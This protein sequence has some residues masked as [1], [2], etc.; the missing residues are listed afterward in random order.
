VA[1]RVNVSVMI[2]PN[3]ISASDVDGSRYR[4]RIS[5]RSDAVAKGTFCEKE[6]DCR[7]PG[8]MTRSRIRS[9]LLGSLRAGGA[10][11]CTSPLDGALE[12]QGRALQR[13]MLPPL[14]ALPIAPARSSTH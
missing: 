10:L 13:P 14:P 4:C 5:M 6:G 8:L 2:R 12:Q 9:A 7:S 11:L 3:R 1:R